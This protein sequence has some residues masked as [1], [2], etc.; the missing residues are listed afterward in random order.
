MEGEHALGASSS[1]QNVA[2]PHG[3][4][5]RPRGTRL[6]T[7][8]LEVVIFLVNF[9]K[10]LG[11]SLSYLKILLD[12]VWLLRFKDQFCSSVVVVVPMIDS[13]LKCPIEVQPLEH[14]S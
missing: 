9:D 3:T 10:V 8:V 6:P 4:E 12:L 11:G 5:V 2:S 7:N 1:S 13:H 14:G